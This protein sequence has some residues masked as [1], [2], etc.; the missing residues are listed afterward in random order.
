MS[1]GDKE[2]A[3]LVVS[4]TPVSQGSVHIRVCTEFQLQTKQQ[5]CCLELYLVQESGVANFE[6]KFGTEYGNMFGQEG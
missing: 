2:T 1:P 3:F 6:G 5:T 4:E